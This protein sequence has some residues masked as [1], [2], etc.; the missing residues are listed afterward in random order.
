MLFRSVGG[1]TPPQDYEALLAAGATAI[2]PPGTVVAAAA[3]DL[4]G[5][6]N[7]TLGHPGPGVAA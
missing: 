4:L 2:Y 6:L 1:V 5:K 3:V 7:D